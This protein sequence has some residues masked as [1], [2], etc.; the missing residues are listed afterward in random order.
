MNRIL[1]VVFLFSTY[2]LSAQKKA[3]PVKII[4]A[5]SKEWISG[6]PGGR[7]GTSYTI[8][9]LINSDKKVEFKSAWLGKEHVTFEEEFFSPNN[10][11]IKAGDSLL[12]T[13]NHINGISAGDKVPKRPPIRYKGEALIECIVNGKALYIE[14]KNFKKLEPLKGQ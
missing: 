12:L 5:T 8:K 10:R 9:I 14:V 3:V 6:A 7:S 13:Y 2:L 4:E 11:K 1:L